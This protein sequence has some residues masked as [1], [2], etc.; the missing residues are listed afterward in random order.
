MKQS[1]FPELDTLLSKKIT[2]IRE[3]KKDQEGVW[4]LVDSAYLVSRMMIRAALEDGLPDSVTVHRFMMWQTVLEYQMESFFLVI[5]RRLDEGLAILRM[6]AELARDIVRIGNDQ[7]RLDTWLNRAM[8][9]KSYRAEFRFRDADGIEAHVHRLYNLASEFGVHG[10]STTSTAMTAQRSSPD[11]RFVALGVPDLEVYKWLQIWLASFFPTQELCLR[12]MT[13]GKAL[14]E[15][16]AHYR[17]MQVAFEAAFKTF[18]EALRN[19]NADISAR[20]H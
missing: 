19:Q 12:S 9:K 7:K 17:E 4:T 16:E 15:A 20:L 8:D 18:R 10:H 14:A 1:N 5:S 11:G 2:N 3:F 6:A 13:R